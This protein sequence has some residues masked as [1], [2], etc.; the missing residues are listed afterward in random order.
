MTYAMCICVGLSIVFLLI[1]AEAQHIAPDEPWVV[2]GAMY[3]LPASCNMHPDYVAGWFEDHAGSSS[4]ENALNRLEHW[5]TTCNDD[6]V[7]LRYTNGARAVAFSG[8][9]NIIATPGNHRGWFELPRSCWSRHYS[10]NGWFQDWEGTPSWEGALARMGQWAYYCGGGEIKMRYHGGGHAIWRGGEAVV[11]SEPGQ[12]KAVAFILRGV[13]NDALLTTEMFEPVARRITA[14]L[15]AISFG[16]AGTYEVFDGGIDSRSVENS[17]AAEELRVLNAALGGWVDPDYA[18]AKTYGGEMDPT[19]FDLTIP[20]DRET[21]EQLNDL[22]E[23]LSRSNPLPADQWA[24]DWD[25]RHPQGPEAKYWAIQGGILRFG[26]GATKDLQ[27]FALPA[28]FDP[29]MFEEIVVVFNSRD[30]AVANKFSGGSTK[31]NTRGMTTSSGGMLPAE[32]S[33]VTM[34]FGPNSLPSNSDR[35]HAFVVVTLHELAHAFGATNHDEDPN[36]LNPPY[37]VLTYSNGVKSSIDPNTLLGKHRLDTGTNWFSTQNI[38]TNKALVQD[39][40][41]AM[42]PDALYMYREGETRFMEIYNGQQIYYTTDKDNV[43]APSGYS[44]HF[45][46]NSWI[47]PAPSQ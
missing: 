9:T 34:G 6:R 25:N 31:A 43:Q 26:G 35:Q 20:E 8:R 14:H 23:W 18:F 46:T 30:D 12:K 10:K 2:P 40:Y 42:D 36:H 19:E 33:A 1:D 39:L 15:E 28:S 29:E 17:Q 38:T 41:G 3:M 45:L 16:A 21:M 47:Q 44:A 5:T 7:N 32:M 11:Q 24:Q 22:H 13:G 37:S 4:W 27:A